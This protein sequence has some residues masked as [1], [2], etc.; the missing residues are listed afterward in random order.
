MARVHLPT[1][2]LQ[3]WSDNGSGLIKAVSKH[4]AVVAGGYVLA[5][6]GLYNGAANG[7]TE[8][9]YSQFESAGAL[10]SFSGAT[11]THTI[12][13]AGGGYPFN[14]AAVSYIDASGTAHVLVVGG[15]DVDTPGTKHREAWYN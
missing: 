12:A 2:N 15:D 11:G 5:S 7:S 3:P 1:G 14:H 9:S 6:G 8:E 13:S 10:G 4:T